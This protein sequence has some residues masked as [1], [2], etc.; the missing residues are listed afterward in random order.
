M[1][2]RVIDTKPDLAD[3]IQ[4]LAICA[5]LEM[6]VHDVAELKASAGL[7]APQTRMYV[8]HLPGQA[9]GKTIDACIAAREAGLR[10][11][12]HVPGRLIEDRESIDRFLA[13]C[14]RQAEVEEVL[15]IAGD[16]PRPVGAFDSTMGV[17]DSGV[18][19]ETGIRA[20]SVAG[21]PEG[22]PTIADAELRRA[23]EA[24]MAYA[25][26]HGMALTFLTQFFFESA[27]FLTWRERIR[28]LDPN[29]RIVAGLAGPAKLTTLIKFAM[30]C[31]VGPSLR[32][33]K[34][35][36]TGVLKLLG[37]QGP[38]A[39]IY[40]LASDT[41]DPLTGFHLFSFGG[42]K[43]TCEWLAAVRAGNFDLDDNGGF[44]VRWGRR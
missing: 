43:R 29:A 7:L 32:A 30:K 40:D 5:S 21:H 18:L 3:A 19:Q 16:Y 26:R 44:T 28:G 14:V 35:R 4:R 2:S 25:K 37:E 15:L 24:K 10:P 42:L 11:M 17:L 38:E 12:P 8:S 36:P 13:A 34:Q 22:H 27:P 41:S 1:S 9:W 31:G 6:S 33:L 39:L 20:V 23:E